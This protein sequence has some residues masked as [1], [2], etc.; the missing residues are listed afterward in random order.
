[1]YTITPNTTRAAM[2]QLCDQVRIETAALAA[3]E[4]GDRGHVVVVERER[5]R[6]EILAQVRGAR[7]RDGV[8]ERAKVGAALLPG[9]HGVGEAEAGAARQSDL[10]DRPCVASS[11]CYGSDQRGPLPN[12][13]SAR[14]RFRVR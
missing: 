6:A 2:L 8:G 13:F 7:R 11:E 5:G 14:V 1:M 9:Q 3:V 12:A 10:D 4:R